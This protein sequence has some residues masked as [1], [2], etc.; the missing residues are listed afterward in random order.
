MIDDFEVPRISSRTRPPRDRRGVIGADYQKSNALRRDALRARRLLGRLCAPDPLNRT[1]RALVCGS[2]GRPHRIRRPWGCTIELV[3][4][5]W[6]HLV[7]LYRGSGV[8]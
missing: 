4:M 3:R 2:I 7:G 5:V 6:P 1:V 8:P